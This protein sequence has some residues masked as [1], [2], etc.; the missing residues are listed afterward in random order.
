MASKLFRALSL[1]LGAGAVVDKCFQKFGDQLQLGQGLE[2]P[3]AA[4]LAVGD[5][6]L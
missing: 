6:S 3:G 1:G 2:Q 5:V 4:C